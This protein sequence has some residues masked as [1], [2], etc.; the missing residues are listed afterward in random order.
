LVRDA[1]EQ[2]F[3]ALDL[4]ADARAAI[5]AID[6]QYLRALAAMRDAPEGADVRTAGADLNADQT[7]MTAI[8]NVLGTDGMSAFN[9]AERKAE[10][11]V[12]NQ[13]RPESVRG[14]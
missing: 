9:A 5:R 14:R 10:H 3:E 8:A 7:R 6:D 12:H 13:L 11:R 4:P 1:D 2:A